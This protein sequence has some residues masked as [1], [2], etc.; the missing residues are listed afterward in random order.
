[1]GRLRRRRGWWRLDDLA[2]GVSFCFRF[3]FSFLWG[4]ASCYGARILVPLRQ[5]GELTVSPGSSSD[6]NLDL[7]RVVCEMIGKA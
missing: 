1:M 7:V 6:S 2:L 5:V 4:G 3:S